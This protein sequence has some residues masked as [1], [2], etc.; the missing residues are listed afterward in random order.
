MNKSDRIFVVFLISIVIV[1]GSFT[2]FAIENIDI[3]GELEWSNNATLIA[4]VGVGI[5]VTLVVL[6]IAK[7][8]EQKMDDKITRIESIAN[9]LKN[10]VET[11]T[12]LKESKETSEYLSF[13]QRFL[14]ELYYYML[15]LEMYLRSLKVLQSNLATYLGSEEELQ[16]DIVD[17]N[18]KPMK[19]I[20][21]DIKLT[22]LNAHIPG[23]IRNRISVIITLLK[24]AIQ[25]SPTVTNQLIK[26]TTELFDS[27]FFKE[28]NDDNTEHRMVQIKELLELMQSPE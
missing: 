25:G 9:S 11:Q 1:F 23:Q 27:E 8:S 28:K 14:S 15:N 7:R 20:L 6:M 4:E 18:A 21:E 26:L 22:N 12:M 17:S 10:T 5:I 2:Y 16:R 24:N 19:L 13:K 3:K